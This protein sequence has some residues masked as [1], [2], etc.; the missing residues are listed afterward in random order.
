[1]IRIL[2]LL[3]DGVNKL[4]KVVC[5]LLIGYL[6][7]VCTIQVIFRLLNNS[8]SWSEESM[9]YVFI[10]MIL[11]ATAT[12]V[13]EGSGAC[14]DILRQKLKRQT[15]KA[16]HEIIIFTLTGITALGLIRFG[17]I[18]LQ[19]NLQMTSAAMHLPMPLIYASIPVGSA[20]TLLHCING[21]A[22]AMGTLITGVDTFHPEREGG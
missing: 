5:G 12:T 16:I 22:T 14:I 2:N 1:M 6:A 3:S 11:L 4:T 15:A 10:W 18:F 13:K 19:A 21:V 7:V 8:L 9:R 17:W 20:F